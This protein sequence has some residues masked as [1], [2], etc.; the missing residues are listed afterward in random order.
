MK[1]NQFTLLIFLFV[2]SISGN[3]QNSSNNLNVAN[4]GIIKI[5]V[6][7]PPGGGDLT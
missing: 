7:Y 6:P 4:S 5:I 3:A 1:W 2:L